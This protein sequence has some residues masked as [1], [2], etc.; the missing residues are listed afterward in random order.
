MCCRSK[1]DKLCRRLHCWS[2]WKSWVWGWCKHGEDFLPKNKKKR[3]SRKNRRTVSSCLLGKG[4]SLCGYSYGRVFSTFAQSNDN[5]ACSGLRERHNSIDGVLLSFSLFFLKFHG[6]V[7]YYLHTL[8]SDQIP[9][10]ERLGESGATHDSQSASRSG[11]EAWVERNLNGWD[12]SDAG[13]S[14]GWVRCPSGLASLHHSRLS[15]RSSYQLYSFSGDRRFCYDNHGSFVYDSPNLFCGPSGSV[16]TGLT[17]VR[18]EPGHRTH[19][20]SL[21]THS[22]GY[23][24]RLVMAISDAFHIVWENSQCL[25]NESMSFAVCNF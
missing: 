23:V 4:I 5:T 6:L 18:S 1:Q 15:T 11:V 20:T 21:F 12:D 8:I 17:G 7:T 14:E 10:L 25:E 2:D 9:S 13:L 22:V 19:L 16:R 24:E 3:L